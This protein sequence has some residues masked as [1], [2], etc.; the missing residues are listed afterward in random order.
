MSGGGYASGFLLF[1]PLSLGALVAGYIFAY[2]SRLPWLLLSGFLTLAMI[3]TILFVK[4]PSK[5]ED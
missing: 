2:N 4:E 5:A 1:I 3:I